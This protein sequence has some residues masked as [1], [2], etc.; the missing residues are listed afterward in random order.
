MVNEKVN[1]PKSSPKKRVLILTADAGFG[2]RS[3]ANAIQ[4]ALEELYG[5]Q[6]VVNVVNAL[7]EP[8]SPNFLRDSQIRL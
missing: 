6:V 2:H 7:D 5:N 3:A 4:A 1:Q 8:T